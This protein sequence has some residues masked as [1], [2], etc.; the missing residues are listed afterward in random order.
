MS[1]LYLGKEEIKQTSRL[2]A[3]A[4]LKENHCS[5]IIQT[6]FCVQ[7]QLDY[8]DLAIETHI[9]L[10]HFSYYLGGGGLYLLF[11]YKSKP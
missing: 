1:Y 11:T 4:R 6:K 2:S 7:T 3:S 10:L 8:S 9:K 5:K